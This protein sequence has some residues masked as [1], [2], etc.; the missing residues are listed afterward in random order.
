MTTEVSKQAIELTLPD[1][2]V[3]EYPAGITGLAVAESIGKRLAKDALA[4]KVGGKV[5]D[6]SA[7]ILASAPIEILTFSSPDGREVFWHSSAHVM[8]QAVTEL[9][10]G[11]K[12]AIGPP[13]E[14]GFYYDFDPPKPFAADDLE[15]IEKRMGEI[16]A[17]DAPF[18]R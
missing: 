7:P 13:I 14:E 10:P 9:F 3:R 12:L 17:E 1:G 11:T 18:Q 16:I 15:R 5:M 8:A 4:V 6:L 2:S